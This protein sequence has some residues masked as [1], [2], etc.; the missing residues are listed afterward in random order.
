MLNKE[1]VFSCS[2]IGGKSK[3]RV[4]SLYSSAEKVN[5]KKKMKKNQLKISPTHFRSVIK[6][7]SEN[8]GLSP[9]PKCKI[10]RE[11]PLLSSLQLFLIWRLVSQSL[12]KVYWIWHQV[13]KLPLNVKFSDFV[14]WDPSLKSSRF[15]HNNKYILHKVMGFIWWDLL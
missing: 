12:L 9:L 7:E 10:C 6:K 5:E 2:V 3:V 14:Q 15:N 11:C 13:T 4:R 8:N 1:I